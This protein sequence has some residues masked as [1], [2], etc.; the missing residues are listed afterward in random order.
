MDDVEEL[1]IKP[2]REVIEKGNVAVQNAANSPDMLAEA[3]LLVKVG[4]RGLRRIETN[5]QKLYK[6]YTSNFVAALKENGEITNMRSRLMDLL[7]DFEDF[8]EADT[9]EASRFKELQNLGREVAL[10]VYNILVT[11]KLEPPSFSLSQL[12]PPSSPQ[13]SSCSPVPPAPR[14]LLE[15]RSQR[16]SGSP[17]GSRG[18]VASADFSSVEDATDQFT[19]LT[20]NSRTAPCNG[21]GRMDSYS[22]VDSRQEMFRAESP[23]DPAISPMGRD[24]RCHVSS[25]T[26]RSSGSIT[27][28]SET[29]IHSQDEY[30]HSGSSTFSNST[31]TTC[32]STRL[33]LYPFSPAIPEEGQAQQKS[34]SAIRYPPLQVRPPLAPVPTRDQKA[35]QGA[36]TTSLVKEMDRQ[37]RGMQSRGGA[38]NVTIPA[39]PSRPNIVHGTARDLNL[40]PSVPKKQLGLDAAPRMPTS[41]DYSDLIPV[42]P[43]P[44]A[45][46]NTEPYKGNLS[47]KGFPIG[48]E[49]TFCLYK[50]FCDGAQEVLRGDIGVKKTKKPG[51]AGTTTVARCTGCLF[52]L[53]FC[54]IERDLN[55]EDKGNFCKSGINYRLRFLQ[56]SHLSAKRV[57]DVL[58]ACVFCVH[59]RRTVDECDS[60]VFTNT[61]ALFTHLSHHPRPLPQVTGITVVEGEEMPANLRND[62]DVWF[63]NPP[64]AHPAQLNLSEIAGN[65]TGVTKDHS[66]KLYGQ[67]LLFDRSPALELCHGARITGITWPEKYN[68]EWVFAWHDGIHASTPADI[69]KLDAPPSE[70]I[71]MVGSSLIRAKSRWKFSQR[72]KEK[73]KGLWL[74]FEKNEVI[75]NISY[76]S[77]DHWCW[78]GTNAKGKWGIF[79][80][81]FLEPSTIQELTAEGAD[82][83]RTLSKEKNK[84]SSMLSILSKKRP[85]GRPPSAA[86]SISSGHDTLSSGFSSLRYSRSSRGTS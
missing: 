60:T 47:Q 15:L 67:K 39:P 77:P 59:T 28:G 22:P 44:H 49:S 16:G 71:R 40:L 43:V 34:S 51:F 84:S 42:G 82:R 45:G 5:C 65:A 21:H 76:E 36:P 18:D 70:E 27:G 6:D 66:R 62:Y 31:T 33:R 79:P 57:D 58:Y 46:S 14:H 9:F 50:G 85:P 23:I 68:G 35:L 38:P 32:S 19:K 83:A 29:D 56:K 55:K 2:F 80:K 24:S 25:D 54:Q 63:K 20:T 37:Y 86:D 53:D 73:D 10:K 41:K 30:S 1:V 26:Q 13:P 69:I 81:V 52:E 12:S 64:E 11:M 7:W 17:S 48:P 74:R 72:E 4:E 78:S 75:T 8:I 3:Q 61:K